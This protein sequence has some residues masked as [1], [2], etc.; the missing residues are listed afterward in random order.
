MRTKMWR[1]SSVTLPKAPTIA[2][3][4]GSHPEPGGDCLSSGKAASWATPAHSQVTHLLIPWSTGTP[5]GPPT[6]VICQLSE[7]LFLLIFM[8][9]K[10][11]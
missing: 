9:V 2:K 5:S 6:G 10:K 7:T 1:D 8:V 4:Q 3:F 11:A